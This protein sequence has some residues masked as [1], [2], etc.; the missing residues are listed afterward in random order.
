[1][2]DHFGILA[3]WYEHFIHPKKPERLIKL[4]GLP[5]EGPLLDAGGGTGRISQ[6]LYGLASS[7]VVADLSIDMLRQAKIKD[8][9]QAVCS[10]S[11][12]LPFPDETF[13]RVI[14]V[15]ALH[16]V[17]DH[18]ETTA[19]LWRLVKPGGRI[20]I[21]EPDIRTYTVKMIAI[22]EKLALMR[23]H[24]LSAPEIIGLFQYPGAEISIEYADYN[25]W[26]IIG[27]S[28]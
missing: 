11:E 17:C 25:A 15:D 28:K 16:H 9:L 22:A 7:L 6:N 8:G 24:F 23:S 20:V 26:V 2:I 18:R 5:V 4:T 27:K 14:M 12:K 21:E 1:M 19:E 3:P 10:H 13:D